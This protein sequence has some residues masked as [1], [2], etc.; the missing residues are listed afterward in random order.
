MQTISVVDLTAPKPTYFTAG[1]C[2]VLLP[3][4]DSQA[5]AWVARQSTNEDGRLI[6]TFHENPLL[7]TL[8]YEREFDDSTTREYATNTTASNIFMELDA[9]G[10]SVG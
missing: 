10:F 8:L 4:E 2:K 7:N 6:G 9:D 5:I 1:Y 3:N